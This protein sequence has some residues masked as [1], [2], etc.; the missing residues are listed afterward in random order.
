MKRISIIGSTGSIG[1][2]ALQVI[3]QHSDRF[4]VA[5]LTAN[6]DA[7]LLLLQAKEFSPSYVGI[8]SENAYPAIHDLPMETGCGKEC[9]LRAATCDCDIVLVSVVGL[10]GLACVL[11]AL[12][13]GKTV[14]LANKEPLV[15]AGAIVTARA[16][17]K[18]AALLPVVSEH[19]AIWQ[20]L[21]GENTGEIKRLLLTASGGPF[22]TYTKDALRSVT[23]EQAVKHP[24]WKMG[25]KISVDSATMMNKGLEI[26][27]ARWL[28]D[29]EN[30]DYII[31]PQSI[32]HSMVEFIDG[33]TMAQLSY[34]DMRLPIQ[35][36]FSYPNR[37]PSA[38]PPIFP[39]YCT[40]EFLPPKEDLFPL[41]ALAKHS[42][43]LGGTAPCVLNAAN[44]AA[45]TLF[46][47]GKIGFTDIAALVEKSLLSAKVLPKPTEND[48]YAT[49]NEVYEK[50]MT[51]YNA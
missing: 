39:P 13:A 33:A 41:P 28:F 19:S 50:L 25:K 11:A 9:M 18:H 14:A 49:H 21:R 40:L 36:A 26:I 2:Q 37:I 20:C 5:A 8:C 7:E 10:A 48:I 47:G 45:V 35:L 34:P 6:T 44:E 22:Y 31:H 4:K 51:D 29:C 17:E 12:D 43:K 42:L 38:L 16:R 15:A 32:I 1:T 24:K 3:K 30:V 46:L 23:P 27:E